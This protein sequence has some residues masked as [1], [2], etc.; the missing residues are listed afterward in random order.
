MNK[1]TRTRNRRWSLALLT[2]ILMLT[3]SGTAM[4][5][6]L[7][8]W[9]IASVYLADGLHLP[10]SASLTVEVGQK[11]YVTYFFGDYTTDYLVNGDK[12]SVSCKSSKPSVL[13]INKKTGYASAKKTGKADITVTYKKKNYKLKVT[14]KK[15]GALGTNKSVIKASNKSAKALAAYYG[16]KITSSN[17]YKLAVAGEPFVSGTKII[18]YS[19]IGL[20]EGAKK[21]LIPDAPRATAV[22][23]KISTYLEKQESKVVSKFKIADAS[24]VSG[25]K[26]FTINLTKA[27]SAKDITVLRWVYGFEPADPKDQGYVEG[28]TL[29]D[30]G[31]KKY[32]C[33]ATLKKGSKKLTVY[34]DREDDYVF[35]KG[36]KFTVTMKH[37]KTSSKASFTVE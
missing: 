5:K 29:Q 33:G 21:L 31:G 32:S 35:T 16:K 4:A 15:K 18:F 34:V 14:V 30:A 19:D 27:P 11:F 23:G 25:I 8:G 20:G 6:N 1:N 26:T 17:A 10:K 13:S 7:I 36:D 9:D 28:I 22:V 12:I 3:F 2:L 24:A 37:N